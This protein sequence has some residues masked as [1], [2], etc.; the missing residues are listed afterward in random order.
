MRPL[1]DATPKPLLAV[2]GRPLLQWWLEALLHS[3]ADE[4]VI[5][6]A[7]LGQQVEDWAT[8]W[9]AEQA[10]SP[11]LHFSPEGRDFGGA[12]ETAGGIARALPWLAPHASDVFAVVA[13]DIYAPG[14]RFDLDTV[15]RFIAGGKLAHLWLV[16]NPP[17]KP[18]GDFGLGTDGLLFDPTLPPGCPKAGSAPSGG[19]ATGVAVERRGPIFTFAG[20][21]LYRRSLFELPWSDI[22]PGNRQGATARLAPLLR[23]AAAAGQVS[24]ELYHGPWVDVGTPERLAQLNAGDAEA[25]S[26]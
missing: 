25:Y 19:S 13:G 2:R 23:K 22:P 6:T 3:G 21:G 1:T 26:A 11:R 12:L 9:Q 8:R 5:N 18:E 14:F 4:L 7:W 24:A 10:A 20:I 15:Q 17:H 16:P